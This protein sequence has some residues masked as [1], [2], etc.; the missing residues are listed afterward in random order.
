MEIDERNASSSTQQHNID[1]MGVS[2]RKILYKNKGIILQFFKII[3]Y[4]FKELKLNFNKLEFDA[5]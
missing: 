3:V 5:I 4:E 1:Q 2:K